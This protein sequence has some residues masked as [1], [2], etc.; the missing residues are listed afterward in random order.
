MSLLVRFQA[1]AGL[2]V[3]S[4]NNISFNVELIHQ[5]IVQLLNGK[6]DLKTIKEKLLVLAE[7]G[8]LVFNHD[9]EIVS[10]RV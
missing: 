6:N 7:T 10:N 9:N 4:Q 3:T 1:R 5:K 8:E 2:K